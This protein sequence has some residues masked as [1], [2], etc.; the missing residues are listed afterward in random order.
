MI[1]D[2][3]AAQDLATKYNTGHQAES[4][5]Q[6]GHQKALSTI[7]AAMEAEFAQ[8]Q[9]HIPASIKQAWCYVDCRPDVCL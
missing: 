4:E 8:M 3:P 5:I 2:A 9:V 1:T 7:H 6:A